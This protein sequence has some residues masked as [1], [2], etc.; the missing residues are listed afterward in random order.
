MPVC[1]QF[2]S[3]RTLILL[4]AGSLVNAG[5]VWAAD[6]SG[7]PTDSAPLPA[8]SGINAKGAALGGS[9]YGSPLYGATGAVTVPIL[10]RFGVQLDGAAGAWD[11][12]A[13]TG[14][15][16]HAFWRDPRRGL[17]GVYGS[18][19]HLDDSDGIDTGKIAFEGQAYLGRATLSAVL[20]YEDGD[21][22]ISGRFYDQI[23]LSYYLTDDFRASIGHRY[24]FGRHALALGGEWRIPLDGNVAATV[25]AEGRIGQEDYR[26]V[27]GGLRL[28]FGPEKSLIRRHRE[29]D[30]PVHLIDDLG[31]AT[32]R[33]DEPPL[34]TS[35]PPPPPPPPPPIPQ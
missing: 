18:W 22:E 32:G 13:F 15:A 28:Y 27:W 34:P 1:R 31:T 29:D 8:V 3:A 11:G 25:F 6:M 17:I 10:N 16:G 7:R 30:P 19:I 14:V 26:G 21:N 35:S 2:K 12:S 24:Q 4:A 33:A 9:L 20:G 5:P 23:D